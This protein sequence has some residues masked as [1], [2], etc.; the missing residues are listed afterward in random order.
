[1]IRAP[2]ACNTRPPLA[3]RIDKAARMTETIRIVEEYQDAGISGATTPA[4]RLM[5]QVTGAFAEFERSLEIAGD[6]ADALLCGE[7][8]LDG[9]EFLDVALDRSPKVNPDGRPESS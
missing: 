5:F 4:G 7:R 3:T 9:L 6:G 1:M 2:G 8:R